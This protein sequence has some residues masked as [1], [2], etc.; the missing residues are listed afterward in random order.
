MKLILKTM[1]LGAL[2]VLTTAPASAQGNY[3]LGFFAGTSRYS[4]RDIGTFEGEQVR[5][6]NGWN[7]GLRATSVPE[8]YLGW[9]VGYAYNRTGFEDGLV[10][11]ALNGQSGFA[12]HQGFGRFMF[13]PIKGRVRP[14]ASGGVHFGNFAFPGSS[15]AQGGGENKWGINY[16]GG[17][18][19]LVSDR[20]SVRLDYQMFNTG[21]PF[22]QFFAGD[23][24]LINSQVTVGWNWVF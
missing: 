2:A 23:G 20:Y 4:G 16:G 21:K 7:F 3:D 19:F 17:V 1:I 14:F 15:A 5:I 22:S 6:K 10:V 8:E 24:R 13:F 12:Q 9:E 18:R 11:Q